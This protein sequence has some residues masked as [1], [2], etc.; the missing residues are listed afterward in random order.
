[1]MGYPESLTDPSYAGQIL[2]MTYPLV[3]NYGVPERAAGEDGLSLY[4][5]SEKSMSMHWWS[6]TTARST[7]TGMPGK[8]G[9]MAHQRKHS[10]NIRCGHEG[11]YQII[12]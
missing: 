7:V 3:G 8:P 9:T 1:M 11:P 2:V 4:M 10:R 5:E 12:A 6:L